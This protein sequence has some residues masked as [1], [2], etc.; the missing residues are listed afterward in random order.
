MKKIILFLFLSYSLISVNWTCEDIAPILED[1]CTITQQICDYSQQICNLLP[2]KNK[3]ENQ[4][5]K[6]QLVSL[7]NVLE[8]QVNAFK[9]LSDEMN[10]DQLNELK[11]ELVKVRDK[12]KEQ[13][14]TLKVEQEKIEKQ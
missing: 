12:L 3:A 4:I 5:E 9:G 13:Y 6:M 10:E 1:V 11:L 2:E 14:E 8:K 7:R